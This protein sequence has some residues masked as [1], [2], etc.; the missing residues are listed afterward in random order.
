[1]GHF[2]AAHTHLKYTHLPDKF[3]W[4]DNAKDSYEEAFKSND[5]R[6]KL[7]NIDDKI[8]NGDTNVQS[9]IE[10][11][12]DIIVS[13]GNVS[14]IRKSFKPTKKKLKKV[15]KKWF[16]KDCRSVMKELKALKNSF[17]RN[18]SNDAARIKYFKKF[19]EY[20]RLIKY[21]RRKYRDNLTDI[22]SKTMETDPQAAWK[23]I[24]ELKN[25]S[26][27]SDKAERINRTQWYTHF[28]DLLKSNNIKI[29]NERLNQIKNELMD[30]EDANQSGNLDYDITVNEIMEACKKLK[31]NKSS[32]YDMIKNEMLR[33]ALPSIKK[34]VAKI[35]NILLKSGQFPESWKEGIIVPIYKQGNS[36]DSNNYRGITISSCLSKLF[37][38]ILNDRI[39]K[40]LEDKSFIRREQAG[41]RKYHRTS[42]QIF[43]LK[44]IIDKHIH[45]TGKGNKLYTCFIDFRKAFDTVCHDGL[46]LK[47]QRAGINGKIYDL[48]KSMY[49][50]PTSKVKCKNTLTDAIEIKQGVHQGNVLSPLL[51]NIFIND[52]GNSL[53][54]HDAPIVHDSKVNHLLYADDLVLLSTT[55]EGL[56]RNIDK[57][58]EYCKQW[59]LVIN[60][61]KSKVMAFSKERITGINKNKFRF[62]IGNDDIEY[63]SQYKY[64]GV[65][66]TSNAKFSVAENTLSMKASR[67]LFSIKQSIFDKT[68]KPSSLLRIF[69]ALVKP[70]ALYG[71]EIWSGYKSCYVGKTIEE[72]FEMT[73]KN[74]NEFDKTYMR[75]CKYTLGVHSKACNFAVISELGLFP[76]IISIVA[77]CINFWLHTVHS[78]RDSLV[79]KAYL[80]QKN[81]CNS[82][83]NSWLQFVKALLSDLGFSHVW[84]NQST[85]NVASLL[86]SVKNKLKERFISFWQK[87]L[88]SEMKGMKKIANL[89]TV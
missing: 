37:C 85:L 84:K 74:T 2:S 68:I 49:Q 16:D 14:L 41:F 47:L 3:L 78:H 79:H 59:G 62:A 12:T 8:E 73:L 31:N 22:L 51:F 4:S 56:Q 26:L 39:S 38:H 44:T 88:S 35:F 54:L 21:K 33:S 58:H 89:Q 27:P 64:L 1:M 5:I 63:V 71:S 52:I 32:A 29:E 17:N 86:F 24:H 66:F 87:R 28:K 50:N 81:S 55:E 77:N 82:H 40:F 48:I 80:E 43:I 23:V 69:D 30:F 18:V 67:A 6:L 76:L 15:N 60:T 42:D 61:D 20:K 65:I 34:T 19:K 53:L 45:K 10:D 46:L 13:A 11:I 36:A 25:E 9:M 70:I 7:V 72:M 83:S 75:F 57:V